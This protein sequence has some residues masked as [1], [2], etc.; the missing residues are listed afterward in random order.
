MKKI[1]NQLQSYFEPTD[2]TLLLKS[3]IQ[4][5]QIMGGPGHSLMNLEQVWCKYVEILKYLNE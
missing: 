3:V 5:D 1:G 2:N 4:P